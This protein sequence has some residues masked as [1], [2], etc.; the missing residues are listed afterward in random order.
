MVEVCAS[1]GIFVV[2]KQF[3]AILLWGRLS[4]TTYTYQSLRA[5][6]MKP[7]NKCILAH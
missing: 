3:I 2:Q 4:L 5:N 7:L 6:E 1:G